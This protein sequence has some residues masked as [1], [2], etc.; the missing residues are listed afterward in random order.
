MSKLA[1]IYLDAG[2]DEATN[3]TLITRMPYLGLYHTPQHV[4][5]RCTQGVRC[6]LGEM[7]SSGPTRYNPKYAKKWNALRIRGHVRLTMKRG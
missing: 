7:G 6:A 1:T 3:V 5:L 4:E 2:P